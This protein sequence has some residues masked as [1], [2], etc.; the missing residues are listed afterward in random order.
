MRYRPLAVVLVTAATLGGCSEGVLDPKGPVAAAERVELGQIAWRRRS[1]TYLSPLPSPR[2]RRGN[3]FFPGRLLATRRR[4][5]SS[6][7]LPQ[8][9]GNRTGAK[10]GR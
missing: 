7:L 9:L 5:T 2:F 10:L 4:K 1:G 6:D 8:G 3:Q